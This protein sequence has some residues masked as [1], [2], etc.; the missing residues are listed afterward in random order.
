M[1]SSK[2][3]NIV[4]F[5]LSRSERLAPRQRLKFVDGK[6]VAI[7]AVS[8]KTI[9]VREAAERIRARSIAKTEP[10]SGGANVI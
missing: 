3:A 5:P 10:S 9:D 1:L 7:P 8:A 4:A 6:I 2:G